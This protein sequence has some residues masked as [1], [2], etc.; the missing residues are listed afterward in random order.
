[1]WTIFEQIVILLIFVAVGYTLGKTNI[2][3]PEHSKVLSCLLVYVFL[4][5]SIYKTFASRFNVPYISANWIAIVVS[6]V[7]VVVLAVAAFFFVKI[8][9]K[10]K[11]ERRVFEYSA[12]VPNSGYIGIAV[13]TAVFDEIGLMTF[14]IMALPLQI[15]I[16][17]YGFA[18]LTKRGINF[19]KLINPVIIATALG[20]VIGLLEIKTPELVGVVLESSSG[21]MAPV[22]MLLTGIA[23][24]EFKIKDI[25]LNP[26]IY[27]I[28]AIKLLV[29]P[30]AIG[31]IL[32]GFCD[33]RL[34]AVAV[35]LY[36]LP[37]GMNSVVFPKLVGED[38]RSG[39]GLSLV[40]TIL[41]VLT[42]P[43]IFYIFGF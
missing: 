43:L 4:P 24:S 26:K 25:V 36:A 31:F 2:V 28:I 20:M 15:Y 34:V 14:M 42:V 29:I 1:M 32:K 23:I 30:L 19:K 12:I 6:S 16:Y 22:S 9:T 33:A 11:Y 39:A 18:I 17:T 37:C 40:S 41:S 35:L 3:K 5:C 10:D 27:P 7:I 13:A 8:C 38:C 21:C